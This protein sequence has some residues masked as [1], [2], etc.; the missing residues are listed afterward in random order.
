MIRCSK[1]KNTI[2]RFWLALPILATMVFSAPLWSSDTPQTAAAPAK[3]PA[4][5]AGEN[6]SQQGQ[7]TGQSTTPADQKA[8]DFKPSEEISEDFPIPLPSD[9]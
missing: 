8:D 1:Y 5:P 7:D 4:Q 9:I 6:Q 2:C 3:T